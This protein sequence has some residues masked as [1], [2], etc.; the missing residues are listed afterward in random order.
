LRRD[1]SLFSTVNILARAFYALGDTKTPMKISLVCL[2]INFGA[3]C[4]LLPVARRR[5]GH[6]QHA[7]LVPQ[8][9]LLLFAL[10]KKLGK[11]EMEPLRKILRPL[12][13][14]RFLPGWLPGR[15]GGC[16]KIPGPREP[17]AENWRGVCAG[18]DRGRNLLA[19][20]A[21]LKIPAAKEMTAF[22]LA[23]CGGIEAPFKL[24]P[25]PSSHCPRNRPL[26]FSASDSAAARFSAMANVVEPLPD[27]SAASAPFARKNSWNSDK[28]RKFFQRGRFER[29]V[30]TAGGGGKSPA[31]KSEINFCARPAFPVQ[32]GG[33]PRK[34]LIGPWRGNAEAGMNQQKTPCRAAR[35]IFQRLDFFAAPRG[36]RRF[37]LE[38]KGHVGTERRC[39][40]KAFP[41]R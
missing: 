17:R 25:P 4:A 34:I 10:R 7:H 16:G 37:V 5:P 29:I 32:R 28:H 3:T 30:K 12:A 18:G 21:A 27:M 15:P 9:G 41:K 26:N 14:A 39:Q 6:R 36:Q 2:A 35:K 31:C 13:L 11:L 8:L 24:P 1:S 38:K 20:G 40:H 22:A 23:K 19:D 33:K